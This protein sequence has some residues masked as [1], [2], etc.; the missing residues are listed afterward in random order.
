MHVIETE[1]KTGIVRDRGEDTAIAALVIEIAEMV[2]LPVTV[3]I[4]TGIGIGIGA[5]TELGE[6]KERIGPCPRL[7]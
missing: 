7:M 3:E 4:E 1:T 5:T 6:M 2:A